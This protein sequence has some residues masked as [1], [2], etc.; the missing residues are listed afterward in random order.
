MGVPVCPGAPT[1][2][3]R[4]PWRDPVGCRR[5]PETRL[6]R[7]EPRFGQEPSVAAAFPF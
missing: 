1:S 2:M 3:P 5:H 6:P 7:V 4:Q